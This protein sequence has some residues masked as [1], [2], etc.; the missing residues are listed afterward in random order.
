MKHSQRSSATPLLPW[1][2][3]EEKGEILAA[4]CTCMAWYMYCYYQGFILRGGGGGGGGGPGI[5]HIQKKS[6]PPAD[7]F[8]VAVQ[9]SGRHNSI[10]HNVNLTVKKSIKQQVSALHAAWEGAHP[11][12]HPPLHYGLSATWFPQQ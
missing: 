7:F 9:C 1:I 5:F 2:I 11:P 8:K 10:T 4:H 3:L 6:P 12:P